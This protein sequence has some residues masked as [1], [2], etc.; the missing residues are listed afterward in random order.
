MPTARAAIT[1]ITVDRGLVDYSWIDGQLATPDQE[2]RRD[3]MP[4]LRGKPRR[5]RATDH[6]ALGRIIVTLPTLFLP[7]AELFEEKRLLGGPVRR[8]TCPQC[9]ITVGEGESCTM[10]YKDRYGFAP[11]DIKPERVLDKLTK[12]RQALGSLLDRTAGEGPSE[13]AGS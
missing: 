5:Y 9:K 7:V 1:A 6:E 2:L 4:L 12:E 8:W 10:C 3:L 13:A 11:T